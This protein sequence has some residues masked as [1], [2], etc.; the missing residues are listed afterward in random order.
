MNIPKN[1]SYYII[2]LPSI[3]FTFPTS[4]PRLLWCYRSSHWHRGTFLYYLLTA[5]M[6]KMKNMT[7]CNR[8]KFVCKNHE[9]KAKIR[10][11][12]KIPGKFANCPLHFRQI[13]IWLLFGQ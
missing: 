3:N 1:V 12:S 11:I 10:L 6:V 9:V 4:I 7:K 2:Y 13:I 5:V 8:F